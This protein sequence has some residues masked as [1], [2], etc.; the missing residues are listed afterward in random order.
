MGPASKRRVG[1]S[2]GNSVSRGKGSNARN[3]D[4]NG[5]SD[6]D[7][8]GRKH[9][10]SRE[11]GS[12]GSR[13]SRSRMY[14]RNSSGDRSGN[15]DMTSLDCG[16]SG[17]RRR[18][19]L[20][21]S[22]L[23]RGMS[24]REI[25]ARVSSHMK[26]LSKEKIDRDLR[27]MQAYGA[28]CVA[29]AQQ[30]FI[31]NNRDL[32]E[33]AVY[34]PLQNITGVNHTPCSPSGNVTMPVKIDPEQEKRLAM[35]RKKVAASEAKREVLETEYLSLR[36][37]YV[38]ESH[39]LRRT[40][41][42]VT[43]Q[44][45]LLKELVQRRGEVL[46]LYRVRCAMAKDILHCLEYR[47]QII[48]AGLA[49]TS[50]AL[51]APDTKNQEKSIQGVDF[52]IF[53]ETKSGKKYEDKDD[54]F[55]VELSEIWSMIESQLLEAEEACMEIPT[56]QELLQLKKSLLDISNND[57]KISNGNSFSTSSR[58][59]SRIKG[60]KDQDENISKG[61]TT[62]KKVKVE[63]DTK[64]N[65]HSNNS[66][67]QTSKSIENS[68]DD[69]TVENE[70]S[71][72]TSDGTAKIIAAMKDDDSIIPWNCQVIPRT[73]HNVPIMMS[74]LSKVPDG[75]VAFGCGDT[76]GDLMSSLRWLESNIPTDFC[77]MKN[78]RER[79]NILR[80]EKKSLEGQLDY[81]MNLNKTLQEQAITRRRRNDEMCAMMSMIRTETEALLNR[82]NII[83]ETFEARN[84]AET[85]NMK[86]DNEEGEED[87]EEGEE[88]DD[89]EDDDGE[90]EAE[91]EGGTD[92][93]DDDD[94]ELFG[95]GEDNNVVRLRDEDVP[96]DSDS[97]EE[98]E[99]Q[100]VDEDNDGY[101]EV[102]DNSEEEE[103]DDDE[104]EEEGEQ[105]MEE[106]FVPI[107][108]SMKKEEDQNQSDGNKSDQEEEVGEMNEIPDMEKHSVTAIRGH[109]RLYDVMGKNESNDENDIKRR[110]PE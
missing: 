5:K 57:S 35:L 25:G 53:P 88:D 37:H 15:V 79:L 30:F 29:Y 81:E 76:F 55:P 90:I 2:D 100:E 45:N 101:D 14:S 63:K 40:R 66:N 41:N 31:Y 95:D 34:G 94:M 61:G 82:H 65:S 50:N 18:K 12:R 77:D 92:I 47:E 62:K 22:L 24:S 87:D 44:L 84:R 11:S 36:A 80:D 74:S 83:L 98:G 60:K 19:A 72:P 93:E 103:D 4:K 1:P 21:T 46:A 39:Q 108:E 52:K 69:S 10:I 104:E 96:E 97:A 86:A 67:A 9:D 16:S 13:G 20:D 51:E 78:E 70:S 58:P 6:K 106:V 7:D 28:A 38:Y 107:S 48:D 75:S 17:T 64:L 43:G 99:I 91:D 102:D 59:S 8:R 109:K 89:E 33:K 3:R 23:A 26:T 56:P 73:P 110:K 71:A 27:H 54:Q 68:I 32:I 105:P 42:A 49:D 85:F